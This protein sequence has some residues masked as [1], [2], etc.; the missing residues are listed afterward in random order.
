ML[1]SIPASISISVWGMQERLGGPPKA[2]REGNGGGGGRTG[3]PPGLPR[4]DSIQEGIL[5]TGFGS[6]S[7]PGRSVLGTVRMR[8]P[9]ARVAG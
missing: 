8:F 9:G 2:P 4:K 6:C 3:L 1:T 5:R 7:K